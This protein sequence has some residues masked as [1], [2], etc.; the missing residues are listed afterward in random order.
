MVSTVDDE[1]LL[2]GV[3]AGDPASAAA[4]TRRYQHRVY[5]LARTIVG[6]AGAAEDVS[7]EAFIRAWRH[8]ATYDPRRGT[9]LSW[10]LTI[11]RNLAIDAQR[12]R[13]PLPLDPDVLVSVG[14][15]VSSGCSPER[16]AEAADDADRLRA[17]LWQLAPGQRR[18]LVLAFIGGR[19]Y[20][21]VSEAEGIPL[22]TAKTRIRDGWPIFVTTSA[23]PGDRHEGAAPQLCRAG[24]HR[25]RGRLG[26][27]QRR[28]TESRLRPSRRL[29][30][31]SRPGRG[32]D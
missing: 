3:A 18:A 31:L 12:V 19:S 4:F 22:G 20:R 16:G 6:D 11:T 29:R 13:Q 10:L 8:A 28:R 15:A 23:S 21:E 7:Q 27:P 26:D 32:A 30:A 17:A 5:G 1:L 14:E 2:A 25:R 9:A 24:R